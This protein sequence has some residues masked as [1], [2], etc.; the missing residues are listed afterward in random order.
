MTP[1]QKRQLAKERYKTYTIAAERVKKEQ[2]DLRKQEQTNATSPKMY[3]GKCSPFSKLTPKQRR[4]EDRARFQTQV[5]ETP[6]LDKT[7]HNSLENETSK[8]PT[9]EKNSIQS[10]VKSGIPTLRKFGSATKTFKFNK[11]PDCEIKTHSTNSQCDEKTCGKQEETSSPSKITIQ[12]NVQTE[13][14]NEN[15]FATYDKRS[16]AN[17][18]SKKFNQVHNDEEEQEEAAGAVASHLNSYTME[19]TEQHFTIHD[20]VDLDDS[21]SESE[22]DSCEKDENQQVKGPRIVKPGTLSRDLSVESDKSEQEVPK[23]I[24]GRRKPLYS[25]PNTRKSTPQ[26]SPLKQTSLVNRSNTSP[27]V[28]ATRATTLRQNNSL[29]KSKSPPKINTNTAAATDKRI[30]SANYSAK[31][32]SIPQKMIATP[33]KLERQGTFTKDEPEMENAPMVLPMSPCKSNFQTKSET[34]SKFH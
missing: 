5:L 31:R 25:M 17:Q 29:Q 6:V 9:P 13:S 8:I 3:A 28:R 10:L 33:V 15:R 1:K 16:F 2:E 27:I 12:S 23:G 22:N 21:Q 18:V 7:A 11:S 4:Q 32:T 14:R 26:S 20:K 19:S 24:R 34:P 30:A